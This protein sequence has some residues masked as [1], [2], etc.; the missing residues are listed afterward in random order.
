[1]LMRLFHFNLACFEV[2]TSCYT[3]CD[4]RISCAIVKEPCRFE[5]YQSFEK[6]HISYLS[7]DLCMRKAHPVPGRYS[8]SK[9]SVGLKKGASE[10]RSSCVGFSLSNRAYVQ[11]LSNYAANLSRTYLTRRICSWRQCGIVHTRWATP[12][13]PRILGVVNEENAIVRH[14]SNAPYVAE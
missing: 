13:T 10:R 11:H 8:T 7:C 4:L 6:T 2:I 5:V 1:M 12:F 3:N 14:C 9:G